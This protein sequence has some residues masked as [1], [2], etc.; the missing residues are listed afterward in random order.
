MTWDD[1]SYCQSPHVDTVATLD[2]SK[3]KH[4]GAKVNVSK[5]EEAKEVKEIQIATVTACMR[6]APLLIPHP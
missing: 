2:Y 3:T 1:F 4:C 6:R 5:K